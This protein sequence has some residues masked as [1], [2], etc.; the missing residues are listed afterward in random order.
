MG[1]LFFLDKTLK[2]VHMHDEFHTGLS[3]SYRCANPPKFNLT[4]E[5]SNEKVG[6]IQL[7]NVQFQAFRSDKTTNFGLGMY[8]K[9]SF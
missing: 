9:H 3:N 4:N 2:F 6:T 7:S 8:N 5:G 1:F